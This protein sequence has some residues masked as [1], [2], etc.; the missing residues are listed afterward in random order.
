MD[1]VRE[2]YQRKRILT[3]YGLYLYLNLLFILSLLFWDLAPK[4]SFF[5]S[6]ITLAGLLDDIFGEDTTKGLGGHLG[7]FLKE[8]V[9]NTGLLKILL[10]TLA[11]IYLLLPYDSLFFLDLLLLLLATNTINLL[12]LRP[13]R[14]MKG[15]FLVSLLLLPFKDAS[16]VLLFFSLPFF[17]YLPLDLRGEGM[18]GDT[19][20]NLLGALLGYLSLQVFNLNLRL[21]LLLLLLLLH[22][23]AEIYSFSRIIDKNQLL[24]RLDLLGR[25]GI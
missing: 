21:S 16:L 20:S 6:T 1:L 3:G 13:G 5:F 8:R 24:K 11:A 9:F 23:L 18:L 25:G 12:D 7:F 2:N 19:G 17:Y 10:T 4:W 15:F 22:A 14:A